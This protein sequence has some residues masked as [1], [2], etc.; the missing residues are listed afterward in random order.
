[1][2][3]LE[4]PAQS[5]GALLR[6]HERL[7]LLVLVHCCCSTARL[8]RLGAFTGGRRAECF[9]SWIARF[10]FLFLGGP[11]RDVWNRRAGDG[12]SLCC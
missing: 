3:P 9:C 12:G 7:L 1:M 5:E 6:A 10:R 8:R 2:H 4:P 11:Q